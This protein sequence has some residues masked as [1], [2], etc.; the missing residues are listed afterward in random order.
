MKIAR[1]RYWLCLFMLWVNIG[2]LQG[3][4]A[5]Q[6]DQFRHFIYVIMAVCIIGAVANSAQAKRL[7]MV[8]KDPNHVDRWASSY[9]LT[10]MPGETDEALRNRARAEIR[11]NTYSPK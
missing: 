7:E 1:L 6:D 3:P 9:D 4:K 10:R 11:K 2:L 5:H 8:P